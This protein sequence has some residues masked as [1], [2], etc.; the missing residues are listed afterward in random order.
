MV[1]S[2]IKWIIG[3]CALFLAFVLCYFL[4]F[5]YYLWAERVEVTTERAVTDI[6]ETVVI[7]K[8]DYMAYNYRFSIP[9]VYV[10]VIKGKD[11]DGKECKYDVRVT[12]ATYLSS[13]I[14]DKFNM[15]EHMQR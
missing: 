10:L 5:K 2:V 11:K 6:T 7:D 4:F 15:Q 13:N 1:K 8:Y 3:L 9:E 12:L 14:G